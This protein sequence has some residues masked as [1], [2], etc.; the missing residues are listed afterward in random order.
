MNEQKKLVIANIH[1][2][3]QRHFYV[4]V[5]SKILRTIFPYSSH[6]EPKNNNTNNNNNKPA[7][8]NESLGKSVVWNFIHARFVPLHTTFRNDNGIYF[9]WFHSSFIH[10]GLAL[11]NCFRAFCFCFR[12]YFELSNNLNEAKVF[13]LFF[14]DI[15][16]SSA[17]GCCCCFA[18][19][20]F[21]SVVDF[22]MH[23]GWLNQ[24]SQTCWTEKSS[25]LQ[26]KY[27]AI[28][29]TFF[30]EWAVHWKEKRK[31]NNQKKEQKNA[32]AI[33]FSPNCHSVHLQVLR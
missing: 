12:F 4:I 29:K 22:W 15:E 25:C 14:A 10:C 27:E 21:P 30:T 28:T 23:Q 11:V 5:L 2:Y 9:S 24:L 16:F 13:I 3:V 33:F 31:N 7:H 8:Q 26:R 6:Q 18:F 1:C 17:C 20:C 32:A 19:A